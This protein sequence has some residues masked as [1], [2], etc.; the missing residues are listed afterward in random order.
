MEKD[1]KKIFLLNRIL[2]FGVKILKYVLLNLCVY[3][4]SLRKDFFSQFRHK[5]SSM[6]KIFLLAFFHRRKSE[7]SL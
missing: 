7:F 6:Y 5:T 2:Y 3:F 1:F 4:L